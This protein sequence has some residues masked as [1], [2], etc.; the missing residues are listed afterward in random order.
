MIVPGQYDFN[1]YEGA[2]FD[3]QFQ[4]LDA[5]GNPVDFTGYT[6]RIVAKAQLSDTDPVFNFSGSPHLVFSTDGLWWLTLTLTAE[7]TSGIGACCLNYSISMVDNSN[8]DN[9]L[10]YADGL[11]NVI[12]RADPGVV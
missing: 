3:T 2:D 12:K 1:I 4:L 11:I 6:P 5:A 9:I 8:A 7:D 10:A